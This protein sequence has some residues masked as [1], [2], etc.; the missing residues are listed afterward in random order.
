MKPHLTATTPDATR[1][2]ALLLATAGSIG[3]LSCIAL[4]MWLATIVA[5]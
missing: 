3:A 2:M 1:V 4:M 5:L